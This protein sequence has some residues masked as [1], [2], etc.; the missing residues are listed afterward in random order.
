[1]FSQIPFINFRE[2]FRFLKIF[3]ND[4]NLIFKIIIIQA[5]SSTW[6]TTFWTKENRMIRET[7][8]LRLS[9][10]QTENIFDSNKIYDSAIFNS[11]DYN[12]VSFILRISA[13]KALFLESNWF[14]L[15]KVYFFNIF[16]NCLK[17]KCEIKC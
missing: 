6:N 7:H 2:K 16:G 11:I 13:G 5:R 8:N 15:A 17:T 12:F 10:N 4:L 1:M 9:S 14:S 3:H